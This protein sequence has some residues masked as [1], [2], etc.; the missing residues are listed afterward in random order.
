[1]GKKKWDTPELVILVKSQPEENVLTQCK[2]V[3]GADVTVVN[4]TGGQNCKNNTGKCGACQAEGGGA[5]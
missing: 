2:S 3:H 4:S 1:M 5:S